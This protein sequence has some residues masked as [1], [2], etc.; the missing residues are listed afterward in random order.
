[1]T[2]CRFT[3]KS[4]TQRTRTGQPRLVECGEPAT[5]VRKS[6]SGEPY[7]WA[8]DAHEDHIRRLADWHEETVERVS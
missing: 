7:V 5:W 3:V 1:M 2:P 4:G 8:C 6:R